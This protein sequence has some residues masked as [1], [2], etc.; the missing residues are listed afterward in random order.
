MLVGHWLEG[1]SGNHVVA[2]GLGHLVIHVVFIE[3][4]RGEGG[5]LFLQAPI[6]R[7]APAASRH[8]EYPGRTN[9]LC[10]LHTAEESVVA[11]LLHAVELLHRAAA[12]HLFRG[13]QGRH[14]LALDAQQIV[15]NL[16]GQVDFVEGQDHG[17][18]LFLGHLPENLQKLDFIADVQVGRGLVQHDGLRLLAQGPGQENSLPLAVGEGGKIPLGQIQRVNPLQGLLHRSLV[19]GGQAAKEV[20]IG[21][22]PHGHHLG[23]G[24]Q[25]RANPVCQHHRHLLGQLLGL[26][27]PQILLPEEHPAGNGLKMP[28]DGFENGGFSPAVGADEGENFALF[29][30][31]IDVVNQDAAVIAHCQLLGFEIGFHVTPP[32]LCAAAPSYK[33]PPAR[34]KQR[35]PCRWRVPW[36]RIPSGPADRRSRRTPRRTRSLRE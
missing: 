5:A 36:A 15:G 34:R 30:P 21:I 23:T 11:A 8:H 33:S 9:R 1:R 17:D 27:L 22:P 18:A 4:S 32:R 28:G 31:D 29:Q 16:G 3:D 14:R 19:P 24:G 10:Q 6:H 20:G 35:S 13:A 2:E 7:D 25:L 26:P 12:Q